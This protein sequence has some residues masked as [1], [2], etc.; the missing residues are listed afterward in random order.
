M[1][2]SNPCPLRDTSAVQYQLSLQANWELVMIFSCQNNDMK[3][4]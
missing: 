1:R 2:E 4:I 3:R